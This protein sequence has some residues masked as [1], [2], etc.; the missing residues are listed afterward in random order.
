MTP[1]TPR[2]VVTIDCAYVRPQCAAAYLICEGDE[3]VF[4]ETNTSHAVPL[5]LAALEEQHLSPDRVR[6]IIVTHVHLDHSAGCETLLRSCPNATVLAHPRAVP[7]LV[8]PGRLV[9]SAR[10]VYGN[11]TFNQLYGEIRPIPPDRVRAVSDGE[12]VTAGRSALRFLHTRGHANHHMCVQDLGLDAIFT[13][14]SFGIAYPPLQRNGLFIFPTTSPT[15]FDPVEALHAVRRIVGTGARRFFLTHFGELQAAPEA[16]ARDLEEHLEF[17]EALLCEAAQ[18][19]LSQSELL[20][21]CEERLYRFLAE[22]MKR[23]GLS[24]SGDDWSIVHPDAQINAAGIAHAAA[25]LQA[26]R[27]AVPSAQT[28]HP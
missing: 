27:T 16:A 13:G 4:L 28:L 23:R 11:H 10:A 20:R 17:D 12:E 14:D 25:R 1:D 7:H 5:L 26:A 19:G 9:E 2:K 6:S 24:A 18:A 3:A 8:D 21:F 15:G 22:H